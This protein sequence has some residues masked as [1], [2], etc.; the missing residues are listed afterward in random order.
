MV[1]ISALTNVSSLYQ[2]HPLR[3]NQL[4]FERVVGWPFSKLIC[5]CALSNQFPPMNTCHREAKS[6]LTS[7][8]SRNAAI[9]LITR[10]TSRHY[11]YNV[12]VAVRL[13]V[14]N[15][16]T[17]VISLEIVPRQLS[18]QPQLLGIFALLGL[19]EHVPLSSNMQHTRR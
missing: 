12:S 13:R 18:K 1:I 9:C 16:N 15:T 11:L 2:T 8:L 6:L 4:A 10:E 17:L 5:Q 3:V 7:P 19:C 14:R